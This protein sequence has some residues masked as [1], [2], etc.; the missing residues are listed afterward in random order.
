MSPLALIGH[1]TIMS[2]AKTNKQEVQTKYGI[3]PFVNGHPHGSRNSI[4]LGI[5]L[6]GSLK[7]VWVLDHYCYAPDFHQGQDS[8]E[9]TCIIGVFPTL[10]LAQRA[11]LAEMI[12]RPLAL[13]GRSA[14]FATLKLD[15]KLREWNE[16]RISRGQQEVRNFCR[17]LFFQNDHT[18]EQ[19]AKWC[20]EAM[21][22]H[23]EPPQYWVKA[24]V[25]YYRIVQA[26]AYY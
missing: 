15:G 18:D 7:T 20:E 13:F 8:E 16:I 19:I 2:S 1:R 10:P 5:P 22:T 4:H 11:A 6:I 24:S 26:P 14:S 12:Q 3:F 17:E 25:D 9:D 23:A 21:K